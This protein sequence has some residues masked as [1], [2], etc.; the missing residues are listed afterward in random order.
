M[1][2][3]QV[4]L[5]PGLGQGSGVPWHSSTFH[6]QPTEAQSELLVKVPHAAGVPVQTPPEVP[7]LAV[8]PPTPPEPAGGVAPPSPPVPL[9]CWPPVPPSPPPSGA[10]LA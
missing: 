9:V 10:G 1:M 4:S 3:A 6:L 7:P 5:V 2:A 8:K